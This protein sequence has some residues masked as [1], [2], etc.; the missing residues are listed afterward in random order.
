MK[1][2]M[3]G[4]VPRIVLERVPEGSFGTLMESGLRRFETDRLRRLLGSSRL[5]DLGLVDGDRLRATFERYVAGDDASW[6]GVY[7][8]LAAEEWLSARPEAPQHNLASRESA[9]RVPA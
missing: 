4:I 7:W 9:L 8:A 5:Q 3:A 1:Q 6:S 2:A